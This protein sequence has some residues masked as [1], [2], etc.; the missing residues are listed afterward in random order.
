[1]AEYNVFDDIVPFTGWRV[2]TSLGIHQYVKLT[3][4]KE[5]DESLVDVMKI[6]NRYASD[7]DF[8]EY[9]R[10]VMSLN[11][12]NHSIA[13]LL[14]KIL[15][16]RG[17]TSH[18]E[19]AKQAAWLFV[20]KREFNPED[21]EKH[22]LSSTSMIRLREEEN[23]FSGRYVAV[24]IKPY[25]KALDDL[26]EAM[27]LQK[28]MPEGMRMQK[29]MALVKDKVNPAGNGKTTDDAEMG[30]I[31]IEKE[32]GDLLIEVGRPEHYKLIS[33]FLLEVYKRDRAERRFNGIYDISRSRR[34]LMERL[35]TVSLYRTPEDMHHVSSLFEEGCEG[36][37]ACIDGMPLART[38][39]PHALNFIVN[40]Y[41]EDP[42]EED[43]EIVK[44][45]D[46]HRPPKTLAHDIANFVVM[47]PNID[48]IHLFDADLEAI[49]YSLEEIHRAVHA[50]MPLRAVSL[51]ALYPQFRGIM[52]GN[53]F[54]S[55]EQLEAMS[56][57][58][59]YKPKKAL[60]ILMNSA[61]L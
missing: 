26:R 36:L 6:V 56:G 8:V 38:I 58:E 44:I 9:A 5:K 15:Q 60:E 32:E 4:G 24:K 48:N 19:F 20:S 2:F 23:P 12:E 16:E 22:P 49:G 17:Y 7:E 45:D 50:A 10:R 13:Q 29:Y 51:S 33:E 25:K 3:E 43:Y 35:Q 34:K 37:L 54:S 55:L 11:P 42:E 21:Y 41:S 31:V 1:M 28:C 14:S 61:H 40:S 52:L 18:N 47:Q 27:E 46:E 57:A 30:Y 39:D 59:F 53:A